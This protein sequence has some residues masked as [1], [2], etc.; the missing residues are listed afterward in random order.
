MS[1]HQTSVQQELAN[2]I[3]AE[4]APKTFS[5]GS[6]GFFATGKITVDGKRYQA[7]AQA[8]LVG[9]K[10]DA[11]ARVRGNADQAKAALTAMVADSLQAVAFKSG[12]AGFRTQGKVSIADQP[13]QG[14]AQAVLIK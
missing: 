5:T 14:Q 6:R 4:V 11:K 2:M 1:E 10:G 3:K 9:S 12:K 13:F 7:Q 8:V